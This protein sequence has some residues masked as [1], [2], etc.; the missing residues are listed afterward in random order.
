MWIHMQVIKKRDLDLEGSSF[1]Q[2]FCKHMNLRDFRLGIWIL[3]WANDWT[4]GNMVGQM[5][6]Q[7][8]HG[9]WFWTV[10]WF[11]LDFAWGKHYGKKKQLSY[12]DSVFSTSLHNRFKRGH[13]Q[14]FGFRGTQFWD[15]VCFTYFF[16]GMPPSTTNVASIF[17]MLGSLPSKALSTTDV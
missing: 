3:I 17:G 6:Y 12:N 16:R 15:F 9:C 1:H 2:S 11:L 8:Q 10:F 7:I 5:V 13:G 14:Q 4:C